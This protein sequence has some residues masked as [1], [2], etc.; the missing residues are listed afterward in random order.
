L[1]VVQSDD[2][3]SLVSVFQSQSQASV[4][5][6]ELPVPVQFFGEGKDTLIV[7][8][9][10]FAGQMFSFNPGFRIDSVNFD[11]DQR[12][13]SANN[14]VNLLITKSLVLKPNPAGDV[15]YIMQNIGIISFLEIFSMDGK[16][17]VNQQANENSALTEINTSSLKSGVYLLRITFENGIETRKF[18]VKR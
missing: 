15:L 11:P 9:N 5:F 2:F 4:N 8:N 7:F 17:V 16:L 1:D 12:L 10:T 6:F 14:K 18:V 13:V 3:Q